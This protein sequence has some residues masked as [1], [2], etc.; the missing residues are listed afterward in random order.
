MFSPVSPTLDAN[1][2]HALLDSRR[3]QRLSKP[4]TITA[5]SSSLTL[6]STETDTESD[7]PSSQR[8]SFNGKTETLGTTSGGDGRSRR[9]SRQRMRAH[10]FG[11]SQESLPVESEEEGDNRKSFVDTARVVRDRL[12]R[13]GTM[14]T[15]RA[16]LRMSVTPT[17][18][19]QSRLSLVPE[20]N[21]LDVEDSV[22]VFDQIKE[23]AFFDSLAAMNHV[24]SPVDDDMH[25][26]AIASPIR[27]RSLYTPGL[28]TRVPDDILR[29]PPPPARIQ[30]EADRS[31]Y[32]NPNHPESSPLSMLASLDL[33][34]H[35]R[36]S[37]IVRAST[38]SDMDYAHLGG[39]RLGTLR[40]MNGNN[41]PV[42]RI[43]TPTGRPKDFKGQEDYFSRPKQQRLESDESMYQVLDTHHASDGSVD[44]IESADESDPQNRDPLRIERPTGSVSTSTFTPLEG[45]ALRNEHE[46]SVRPSTSRC[47]LTLETP[48]AR[49]LAFTMAQDYM[50]E[51]PDSPFA[52][53]DDRLSLP[54]FKS[55]SK[56]NE[57]EDKLFEDDASI[58]SISRS[59]EDQRSS[60]VSSLDAHA[61]PSAID[62]TANTDNSSA[63]QVSLPQNMPT[64]SDRTN[65]SASV[66]GYVSSNSDVTKAD[67]GYD[68]SASSKASKR[69]S[70]PI[71]YSADTV[72]PAIRSSLK[73][74]ARSPSGPREITRRPVSLVASSRPSLLSVP[75]IPS[76][77]SG[78]CSSAQTSLETVPTLAS[79]SSS[80]SQSSVARKL[81]KV[82]P[83]SQP[84][85][86]SRITV[87][88]CRD[89]NPASIPPVSSE[90]AA[91]HA[92]RMRNFPLLDHTF[93]SSHHTDQRDIST[94]PDIEFVPIRF[95]SPTR[96]GVGEGGNRAFF[97]KAKSSEAISKPRGR[98]LSFLRRNHTYSTTDA[99]S[100]FDDHHLSKDFN[101][102]E[103]NDISKSL[104]L[105]PYDV[106]RSREAPRK[107]S[108]EHAGLAVPNQGADTIPRAKIHM[109]ERQAVEFARMRS[110]Y[111][112][113]SLSRLETIHT[114]N[115]PRRSVEFGVRPAYL[116][117]EQLPLPSLPSW[118]LQNVQGLGSRVSF[119]DRGG[120]PGKMPRSHSMDVPP[121]PPM[122]T[123]E[124]LQHQATE[125]RRVSLQRPPSRPPPSPPSQKMAPPSRRPPLPPT[126]GPPE[127]AHQESDIK[128]IQS[129][130]PWEAQR[131]SWSILRKSAVEGLQSPRTSTTPIATE[132]APQI[133]IVPFSVQVT[134]AEAMR[135]FHL[136]LT[137]PQSMPGSR[138]G[139]ERS[140]EDYTMADSAHQRLSGRFDGGLSFGYEPG[141][142][143]GG[144]AGT[145]SMATGASRKS[146]GMSRGY[147]I[148][149]SDVPIFVAPSS[150]V[151]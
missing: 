129:D 89:I 4:R 103:F 8:L 125:P 56:N 36:F 117:A 23:K 85:P 146:V 31:Y 126:P 15:R 142:G 86:V 35:G 138:N 5:S 151:G 21:G 47:L 64:T 97:S 38:P 52:P 150:S 44:T 116:E 139:S 18:T 79:S 137:P 22:R 54:S 63:I 92:E 57:F 75:A 28:A 102:T 76:A 60:G 82:R 98:R 45:S 62:N 94:S 17:N 130:S 71:R 104:G 113:H 68:T 72:R 114:E 145:R 19:S 88:S 26:D 2:G 143:I 49:D 46:Y 121:V 149:L 110:H 32:F 78:S 51:L 37:P 91:R 11:S 93:P 141:Y 136:P 12:S 43:R 58:V 101:I 115:A 134:L 77:E 50:S 20:A 10:L 133:P 9:D 40:I 119:D 61:S 3:A 108:L 53:K 42:P 131:R 144:S 1:N 100:R 13:T 73:P 48:L 65:P 41:S 111:R 124:Q 112:S 55:T 123:R 81:Q 66:D 39:L 83:L 120:V 69:K 24:S 128:D 127:D 34:A 135:A 90:V 96:A 59:L 140:S 25:V 16:S 132:N 107:P 29:K 84:P 7:S 99:V 74:S 14:V 27:R 67:S 95:P 118:S 6:K 122:P 70:V 33:P 106:A 109:N 105:S 147:G 30:S 87:Q 148:D 80:Y